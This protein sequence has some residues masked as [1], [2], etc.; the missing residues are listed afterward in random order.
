MVEHD[1]LQVRGE[2]T[3]LSSSLDELQSQITWAELDMD[4][5][6]TNAGAHTARVPDCSRNCSCRVDMA[7]HSAG[8]QRIGLALDERRDC[9][10]SVVDSVG[11]S[12]HSSSLTSNLASNHSQL[13]AYILLSFQSF[14]TLQS[15]VAL[16]E[17]YETWTA[18]DAGAEEEEDQTDD[19]NYDHAG[20]CFHTGEP[21]CDA[22]VPAEARRLTTRWDGVAKGLPSGDP[23]AD[24]NCVKG[25]SFTTAMHSGLHTPDA[26]QVGAVGRGGRPIPSLFNDTSKEATIEMPGIP[27]ASVDFLLADF[28][29]AVSGDRTAPEQ[30]PEVKLWELFGK[31]GPDRPDVEALD[32]E[33]RREVMQ[34]LKRPSWDA[35]QVSCPIFQTQWQGFHGY[36]F[37]RCGSDTMAK[38]VLTALPE[39]LRAL[40]TQLHLFLGWTYQNIWDDIMTPMKNVSRRMY[41]KKYRKSQP[42]QKKSLDAYELR[43]LEWILL[44][45]QAAPVTPPEAKEAFTDALHRHGGYQ[46]GL[47][48][49]YKYKE[50]KAV[51]LSHQGVHQLI[52]YELTWRRNRDVAR[53]ADKG[54]TD[55]DLRQ[56]RGRG[57]ERNK[58]NRSSSA[59]IDFSKV[60]ADASLFCGNKRHRAADCRIKQTNMKSGT[61]G[62]RQ[63]QWPRKTDNGHRNPGGRGDNRYGD[64]NNKNGKKGAEG[65]GGQQERRGADK[66][67]AKPGAKRG[68]SW[69]MEKAAAEA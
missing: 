43:V 32:D 31:T 66:G 5:M 68:C 62:K 28:L 46:D 42:P 41:R 23:F 67:T 9:L 37:Q 15:K 58:G 65:G 29:S 38:K 10:D 26:T 11:S 13:D 57:T 63:K 18:S 45:Q 56:M 20:V 47:D 7:R 19:D 52:Q 40:Y 51:E 33:T 50:L 8:L 4:A 36:W 49:L 1:L 3:R 22:E 2:G 69:A 34:I 44:A 14:A 16:E 17:V 39:P 25:N 64:G 55:A 53:E 21:K 60:P 54:E 35:K 27:Q 59:P 6:R 30:E 61:P 48:K 12:D 24:H